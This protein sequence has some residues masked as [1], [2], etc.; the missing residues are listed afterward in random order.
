LNDT[1]RFINIFYCSVRMIESRSAAVEGVNR[2]L[3]RREQFYHIC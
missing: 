3:C 2:I 1:K